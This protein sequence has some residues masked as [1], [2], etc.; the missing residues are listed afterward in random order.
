[1]P[2]LAIVMALLLV[3]GGGLWVWRG[4]T[5]R[6]R[7]VDAWITSLD[8][9][10]ESAAI[11]RLRQLGAPKSDSDALWVAALGASNPR[12]AREAKRRL[13]ESLYDAAL[14]SPQAAAQRQR[15][16]VD[17]L[18][19]QV[20]QLSPWGRRAAGDLATL[21]LIES[22]ASHVEDDPMLLDGCRRLLTLVAQ[23][24]PLATV[25]VAPPETAMNRTFAQ[26][27]S[28]SVAPLPPVAP[29]L[30]Q[31]PSAATNTL[32]PRGPAPSLSLVPPRMV[33]E[34]TPPPLA[35]PAIAPTPTAP[36]L[37][38]EAVTS[39]RPPL[40]EVLER[41]HAA[42]PEDRQSA[43]DQLT[44]RGLSPQ[45]IALGEALTSPEAS[46]RR[47]AVETLPSL[48]QVD[49]K[50]WLLWLS[51]D[52]DFGVRRSVVAILATSGEPELQ[53]R[54]VEMAVDDPDESVRQLAQR[55]R[56]GVGL[57]R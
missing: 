43:R 29:P 54:V 8:A 34:S 22:E 38:P 24:A 16:L 36:R 15:A 18:T 13:V 42:T 40:A 2:L 51:H 7:A 44:S 49:A 1:M 57:R 14:E 4:T 23:D 52:A 5:T 25:E 50:P 31:P 11:E 41:L 12:V 53:R 45:Q 35:Q 20:E 9:L 27:P 30:E 17:E 32:T 3:G 37:L 33:A 39:A 10:E 28:S 55:A 46:I 48:S 47:R 21:V 26:A 6:S 19:R 56:Q